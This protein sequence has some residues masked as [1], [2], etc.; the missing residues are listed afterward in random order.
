MISLKEAIKLFGL[1]NDELVYVCHEHCQNGV[2][3]LT[4]ESVHNT[5]DM[6]RT[7]VKRVYPYHF[8]YS[9]DFEWELIV[10]KGVKIPTT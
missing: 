6:K 4:V 5:F 9:N 7:M 1:E 8:R 2:S 3:P 10:D